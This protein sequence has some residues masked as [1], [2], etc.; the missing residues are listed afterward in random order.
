MEFI[1]DTSP[2]TS[3]ETIPMVILITV[4]VGE[5]NLGMVTIFCLH[6]QN[7]MEA[8]DT[9][10]MPMPAHLLSAQYSGGKETH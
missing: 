6:D 9:F 3:G 1:T 7:K 8:S 2:S 10:S 5:E 4:G